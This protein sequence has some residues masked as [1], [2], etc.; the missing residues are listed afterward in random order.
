MEYKILTGLG[1]LALLTV[2]FTPTSHAWFFD[3]KT[4]V[5]VTKNSSQS[6]GRDANTDSFNTSSDIR[7]SFNRN[8]SHDIGGNVKSSIISGEGVSIKSGKSV[9]KGGINIAN[10]KSRYGW[11]SGS[12]IGSM[13]DGNSFGHSSASG[14]YTNLGDSISIDR[15]MNSGDDNHV[16]NEK[17]NR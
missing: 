6:A 13:G 10:S 5:D 7:R 1:A 2:L 17:K 3:L 16:N 9:S 12:G 14:N 4:D 15:R 11:G 8:R